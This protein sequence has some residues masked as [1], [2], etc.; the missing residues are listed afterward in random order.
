MDPKQPPTKEEALGYDR[1][2]LE[3]DMERKKDNIKM[4]QGEITKIEM[5]VNWIMQV[6]A[7]IDANK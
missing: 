3:A 5:E 1:A 7:I 2:S 6:I 4:L